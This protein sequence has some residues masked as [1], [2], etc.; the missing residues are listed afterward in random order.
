MRKALVARID[1]EKAYAYF[2]ATQRWDRATVDAQVL[3]SLDE[4]SIMGTKP[5][6]T[7]IMCYQ[8][9]GSITKNGKPIIGG[10]DINETDYAF[11]AKLYPRPGKGLQDL[12]SPRYEQSGLTRAPNGAAQAPVAPDAD[13]DWDSS[14]DISVDEALEEIGVAV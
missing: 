9:P 11:M 12:A 14:G 2:W 4:A 1:R 7:S 6:E 10:I 3:K 13:H 8:L 5:D